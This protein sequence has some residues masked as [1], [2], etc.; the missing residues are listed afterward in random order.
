VINFLNANP[1]GS[2]GPQA[3]EAIPSEAASPSSNSAPLSSGITGGS[4]GGESFA[5]AQNAVD[6]F[7]LNPL[8][9]SQRFKDDLHLQLHADGDHDH[10][11]GHD[12]HDHYE[13]D[14][15]AGDI[16]EAHHDDF[17]SSLADNSTSNDRTVLTQNAEE[18]FTAAISPLTS[19]LL[20]LVERLRRSRFAGDWDKSEL[21]SKLSAVRTALG[22]EL[23]GLNGTDERLS[24]LL[25]LLRRHS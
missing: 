2:A 4:G 10:E 19:N 18:F 25:Q 5:P 23:D 20:S 1:L 14:S 16:G 11:H 13:F 7:A 8:H 21:H 6:Y 24:V 17:F 9:I 22:E 15:H 12:D 3:P